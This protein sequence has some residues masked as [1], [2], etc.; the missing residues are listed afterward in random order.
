M[1][2]NDELVRTCHAGGD[3][4]LD[5]TNDV[6]RFHVPGGVIIFSHDQNTGMMALPF[7]QQKMQIFIIVVIMR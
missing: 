6:M 1:V 7:H 5:G 3:E 4:V 2:E